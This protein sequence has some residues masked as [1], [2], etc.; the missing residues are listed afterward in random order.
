MKM[1]SKE[2]NRVGESAKVMPREH[3]IRNSAALPLQRGLSMKFMWKKKLSKELV[4]NCNG[5]PVL[6]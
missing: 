6:G 4:R 2:K 5:E 1:W 3:F